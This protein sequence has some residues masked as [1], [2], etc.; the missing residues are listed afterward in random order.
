MIP[1]VGKSGPLMCFVSS[2]TS[3]LDSRLPIKFLYDVLARSA[4][5]VG[6]MTITSLLS[7]NALIAST[8]SSKLCGGIL[9]AIPTAIP[10]DPMRSKLGSLAGSTLGSCCEPSNV[11][12]KSTVFLSISSNNSPAIFER[13]ASV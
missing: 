10:S 6:L 5:S 12:T 2:S 11:S 1:A 7:I 3:M 13:R 9:V 8:T 4:S